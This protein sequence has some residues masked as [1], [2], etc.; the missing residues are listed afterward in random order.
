MRSAIYTALHA[1]AGSFVPNGVG[2]RRRSVLSAAPNDA[3]VGHALSDRKSGGS[4]V[5]LSLAA[6]EEA[7][8]QQRVLGMQ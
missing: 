1:I 6:I 8:N 7:S 2:V 5:R 4:S 3:D